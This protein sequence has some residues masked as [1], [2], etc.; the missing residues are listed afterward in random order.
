MTCRSVH[1][2]SHERSGRRYGPAPGPRARRG[3]IV[4]S[5]APIG[6]ASHFLD[7]RTISEPARAAPS[8]QQAW[9][10]IT[11]AANGLTAFRRS[12]TCR[13]TH[14]GTY[15]RSDPPSGPT[16]WWRSEVACR[17]ECRAGRSAFAIFPSTSKVL[18]WATAQAKINLGHLGSN[19]DSTRRNRLATQNLC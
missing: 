13:H 7:K 4:G 19:T 11:E 12:K 17:T 3:R 15:G 6:S 18:I 2:L 8:G 10:A 9:P 5:Q 14:T 1:N 16:C